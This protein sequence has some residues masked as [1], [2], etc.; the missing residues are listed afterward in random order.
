MQG[1]SMC[2]DCAV[3]VLID[4]SRPIEFR[5]TEVQAIKNLSDVGLVPPIRIVSCYA[6]RDE[7][8]G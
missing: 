3:G 5:Y 8:V 6:Q 4:R 2:D 1:T 7:A